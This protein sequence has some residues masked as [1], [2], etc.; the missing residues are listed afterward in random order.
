MAPTVHSVTPE[1]AE[2]VQDVLTAF[3]ELT[4]GKTATIT[5]T[6]TGPNQYT[7]SAGTGPTVT[8]K[9]ELKALLDEM[10]AKINAS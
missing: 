3:A 4:T 9:D 1:Q 8:K 2:A 7:F 6:Q 5:V 10:I